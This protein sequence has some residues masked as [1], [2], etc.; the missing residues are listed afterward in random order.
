MPGAV[1]RSLHGVRLRKGGLA[2][3]SLP[4]SYA[5]IDDGERARALSPGEEVSHER[6]NLADQG[7]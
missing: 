1:Q 6:A 4:R 7:R 3:S 5:M 2:L